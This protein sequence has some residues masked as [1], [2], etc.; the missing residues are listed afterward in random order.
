MLMVTLDNGIFGPPNN[1]EMSLKCFELMRSSDTFS[2]FY[3]FS[4]ICFGLVS[5]K[6]NTRFQ[7]DFF[8]VGPIGTSAFERGLIFSLP[9]SRDIG[10]SALT[11]T[12]KKHTSTAYIDSI[13]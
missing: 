7:T 11:H 5:S 10:R 1:M 13:H 12:H 4:Y 3:Q 2:K 8:L 6:I 9:L